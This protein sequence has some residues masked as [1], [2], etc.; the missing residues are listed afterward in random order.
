VN[1]IPAI[2]RKESYKAFH[3]MKNGSEKR[4]Y[5]EEYSM[6]VDKFGRKMRD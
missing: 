3:Q 1:Q 2:L 6:S 4:G 5:T